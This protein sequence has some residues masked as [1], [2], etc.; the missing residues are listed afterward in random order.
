MKVSNKFELI[1]HDG[2]TG[3]NFCSESFVVD[4]LAE[5]GKYEKVVSFPFDINIIRGSFNDMPEFK[6]DNIELCIAPDTV[7]GAITQDA[8]I[9]DTVLNVSQ[10][11]IDNVKV[12]YYLAIFDGTNEDNL[13]RII[14]IDKTAS[15]VTVQTALVSSFTAATPSYVKITIFMVPFAYLEGSGNNINFEGSVKSSFIP[16][17]TII[18]VAYTNVT[19]GSDRKYSFRMEYF[20]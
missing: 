20:Y 8:S 6:G 16:A 18:H 7:V 10:T 9:G 13:G 17:D 11:V 1:Q 5:I 3:G 12:G 15:T 14:S 4:V 19:G 2:S